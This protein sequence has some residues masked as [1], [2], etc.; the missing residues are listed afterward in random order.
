[1]LPQRR[2]QSTYMVGKCALSHHSAQHGLS[3]QSWSLITATGCFIRSAPSCSNPTPTLFLRAVHKW[4]H[5]RRQHRA[6]AAT[7]PPGAGGG[8]PPAE[9]S[10]HVHRL[11]LPELPSQHNIIVVEGGHRLLPVGGRQ[12][13]REISG[14]L[15]PALFS[16]TPLRPL[17]QSLVLTA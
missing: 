8:A 15:H 5:T 14:G 9:G 4:Q 2:L 1:M 10:I 6:S 13:H 11:Q 16:L 17:I 3:K 12:R 7:L